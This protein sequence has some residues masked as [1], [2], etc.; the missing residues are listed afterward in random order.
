MAKVRW[1]VQCRA[2]AKSTG[3]RCRAYS[4]TGGYVCWHHSGAIGHVRAK[5]NER[6]ELARI[7]RMVARKLGRPLTDAE[8]AYLWGDMAAYEREV[9]RQLRELRS[10]AQD[11]LAKL[12]NT[13]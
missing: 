5:A 6:W 9:R 4:I 7:E 11:A 2:R 8:R 10:D 3:L 1:A 13:L 12:R